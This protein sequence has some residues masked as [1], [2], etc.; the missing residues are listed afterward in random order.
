[1][2]LE[3]YLLPNE[4]I[5]YQSDFNV[6]YG[7]KPYSVIVTDTRLVLYSR[8]GLIIKNDDVVTEAIKDI[9]GITYREMGL[10][11]KSGEVIISGK[12]R[13][14]FGGNK[15]SMKALY[16]KLLPFLSSEYRPSQYSQ[17]SPSVIVQMPPPPP[18]T[19]RETIR[20]IEV[21][22]C[23]YCGTKNNARNTSCTR[24]GA[25]LY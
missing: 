18:T 1:M 17:P 23:R 7:G 13:M 5:R 22:Y 11:V 24:C 15:D 16:Q 4:N 14:Q 25:K 12:S 20:E 9:Q 19:E 21:V 8:R 2:P 10:I 3:D 6:F